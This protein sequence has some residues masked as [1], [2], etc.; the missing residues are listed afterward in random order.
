MKKILTIVAL[1]LA[2]TWARATLQPFYQIESGA[3][4]GGDASAVGVGNAFSGTITG[5][6]SAQVVAAA[7]TLNIS[8]GY[9]G[10]LYV[11]LIAPNGTETILMNGGAYGAGNNLS[12]SGAN[13]TLAS[14]AFV[15]GN[16]VN[17]A[18]GYASINAVDD[19]AHNSG[20]PN[21]Q[22]TGTYLPYQSLL[23]QDPASARWPG[24]PTGPYAD[25]TWTL[26]LLDFTAGDAPLTLNGWSLEL[27]V[28]PEPVPLALALFTAML[29]AL[30]GIK[31]YWQP[32]AK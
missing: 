24:V 13:I 22:L 5:D 14:A 18:P 23:Y 26:G 20:T 15:D 11:Y 3:F 4:G 21:Y 16:T 27:T 1:A 9:N 29:L 8:G 32:A 28:V 12:L 17:T 25:G 6:P 19:T 30:A 7:V 2:A 31:R 10:T